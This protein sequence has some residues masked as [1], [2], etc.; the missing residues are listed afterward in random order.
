MKIGLREFAER[1]LRINDKDGLYPSDLD[2]LDKIDKARSEGKSFI[3]GYVRNRFKW[4][5]F[6]H[7]IRLLLNEGQKI[8]IPMRNKKE[9]G[10]IKSVLDSYHIE[11]ECEEYKKDGKF[12]GYT[13][14]RKE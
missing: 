13:L 5:E 11:F 7:R 3:Y 2:L 10:H 14:Y 12:V 8:F 1:Y 9:L 4:I 6:A